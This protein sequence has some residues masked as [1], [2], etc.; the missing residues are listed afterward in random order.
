MRKYDKSVQGLQDNLGIALEWLG[1]A[2]PLLRGMLLYKWTHTM[3]QLLLVLV[4]AFAV[5][6]D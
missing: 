1:D 6:W 3:N 4:L 5:L 2:S